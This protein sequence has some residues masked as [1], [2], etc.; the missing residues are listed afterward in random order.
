MELDAVVIQ[1]ELEMVTM[2]WDSA[3]NKSWIYLSNEVIHDQFGYTKTKSSLNDFYIRMKKAYKE[4]IDY[5]EVTSEHNLIRFYPVSTQGKETRGG[6]LKKYYIV[7]GQAFKKMGMK[8]NTDKG[9][10][11]CDYFLKVESLCAL[12][13]KYT[14]AMLQSK[15]DQVIEEKKQLTIEAESAQKI[16]KAKEEENK[17]LHNKAKTQASYK[18]YGKKTIGLYM[19]ALESDARDYVFKIGKS[20]NVKARKS[21]LSAATCDLN[22]FEMIASYQACEDLHL[23]IESFIHS[24]LKPFCVNATRKEHFIFNPLFV[25]NLI[26]RI[27]S[28]VDNYTSDINNYIEL[29]D[30]NKYNYQKVDDLLKYN[31][32]RTIFNPWIEEEYNESKVDEFFNELEKSIEKCQNCII[33]KNGNLK[34]C[35][36]CTCTTDTV[37]QMFPN[38]LI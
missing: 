24:L 4:N 10:E 37:K 34:Y 31:R 36:D 15:K 29:L 14:V 19:G 23:P 12:M 26:R 20:I 38:M 17:W 21:S 27:L 35:Q 30:N 1:K 9:E 3:F 25:D 32:F 28:D 6:A 18:L 7:T 22:K 8:A 16:I 33:D 13:M 11:I 2:F 5:M